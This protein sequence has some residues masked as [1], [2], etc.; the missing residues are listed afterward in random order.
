MHRESILNNKHTV[1]QPSPPEQADFLLVGGGISAVTAAQTLRNEGAQGSILLL[2]AETEYPYERPPLTKGFMTD[3]VP[4]KQLLLMGPEDYKSDNIDIRLGC[5]VSSIDPATHSLVDQAGRTYHYGKLLLATGAQ[6][7]QLAVPGVDLDGVFSFRSLIDAMAVRSWVGTH[8]GPVGII[9]T[10]F[11]AMELA[12]SFTRMGIKVTLI[13]RA[14]TVFPRIHS[15]TLS[16]YFIDQCQKHG[17]DVLLGQT[18]RK[19]RGTRKVTG[20]ETASGKKVTCSTVIM[21][22]GTLAQT[23]FLEQSGLHIEDGILVDEF[24]QTNHPDIFASG[25]VASYL[26]RHGDRQRARHW[27]NA[28]KQGQLAA[29]NMLGQQVPYSSVLHYYCDFLDFSFTFLGTSDRADRQ[30]QRGSLKDKSYAE[31]Y[32]RDDRIIGFFST[33]RPPEE[34]R[35]VETLIR[36]RTDIQTAGEQLANPDADIQDLARQTILILQGGGALGAFECG[37]VRAMEEAGIAPMVIGGV[38]IGAINGA[39]IAGNPDNAASAVEAFWDE[40]GVHG[41]ELAHGSINRAL[42]VGTTM[43]WGIPEFFRPRWLAPGVHGEWWPSQWTSIYD[44]NPLRNLL[45]KYID[46]STLSQS[47]VRLIVSAVDVDRGELVFFDSRIDKLTP[48]HILASC[49]LPPMFQWTTI[50]GRHYWDGGIISNSPLEHVLNQCGADNKQVFIVDLFPGERPLPSNLAEVLSRRDE[51][52]YGERI[53]NDG[54]IRELAHDFKALVDEIMTAVEPDVAARLRQRPR[55]VHL[56]GRGA[57]TSITH[58][59]RDGSAKE[60]LAAHYDFSMQSIN[61][62]RKE[63]Y[64]IAQKL[65]ASLEHTPV[66]DANGPAGATQ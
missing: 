35:V 9:G 1:I 23:N 4:S 31:F 38:S 62:H 33:G 53:R 13:D 16:S 26:D 6:P 7:C 37:V 29:K 2:C 54:H 50:D 56:M 8:P 51:I 20:L 42:A 24:L 11:I 25:D 19:I 41:S 65:L 30:I 61:R 36:D 40:I 46:F 59:V 17:I 60:P 21:A 57:T 64:M 48:D 44:I 28:R 32:I 43:M 58:I 39:I 27:E 5:S 55:Y 47:P 12:T 45:C 18:I 49:S 3:E 22:I 10:S 63:G 52:I 66:P 15:E 34:T 14:E